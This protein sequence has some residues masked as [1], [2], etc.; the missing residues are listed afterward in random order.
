MGKAGQ[1]VPLMSDEWVASISKRYIELYEKLIGNKFYPEA[2]SDE[3]VE[4]RILDAL[5]TL[6]T[7]N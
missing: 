1:Q 7:N 6:P 3:E 4:Q 2:L 5:S